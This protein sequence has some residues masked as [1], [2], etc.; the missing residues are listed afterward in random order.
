LAQRRGFQLYVI[1]AYGRV[2]YNGTL[3]HGL[4][5]DLLASLALLGHEDHQ[6]PEHFTGACQPSARQPW[7]PGPI[8]FLPSIQRTEVLGAR[9]QAMLREVALCDHH[10][11]LATSLLAIAD[12]FDLH[13]QCAC[14]F[15]QRRAFGYLSLPA[16]RLEY[17]TIGTIRL[18]LL[19]HDAAK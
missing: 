1:D 3:C 16:R 4:T 15:Q 8:A 18:T 17:N 5:D 11:T 12:G 19:R 10:L 9:D 14:S 7:V 13:P 6:I 2:N